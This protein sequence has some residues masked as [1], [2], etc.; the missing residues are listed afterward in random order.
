MIIIKWRLNNMACVIISKT[1]LSLQSWGD[2]TDLSQIFYV[3]AV[4][5]G[6]AFLFCRLGTELTLQACATGITLLLIGWFVQ[7]QF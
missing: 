2:I 5:V 6:W 3:Y 4:T 1:Y 7:Y